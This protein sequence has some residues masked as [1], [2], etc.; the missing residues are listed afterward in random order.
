MTGTMSHRILTGLAVMAITLGVLS[1]FALIRRGFHIELA[2]PLAWLLD[3]Y[4]AGVEFAVGLIEP[5]VR[6]VLEVPRFVTQRDMPLY[7]HW[8][9]S[10]VAFSGLGSAVTRSLVRDAMSINALV[11]VA[12]AAAVG[13]WGGLMPL[14]PDLGLRGV[15]FGAG[16]GHHEQRSCQQ[17]MP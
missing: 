1:G 8:K 15:L 12:G 5:A 2:L 17:N 7:P 13:L 11:I 16:G 10:L 6:L 14:E 9:H 4:H 3:A